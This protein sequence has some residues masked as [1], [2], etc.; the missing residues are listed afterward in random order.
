MIYVS[1][2]MLYTLHV[3]V[4]YV[5][6]NSIQEKECCRRGRNYKKNIYH[7]CTHKFNKRPECG[8]KQFFKAVAPITLQCAAL[9]PSTIRPGGLCLEKRSTV[10]G[11]TSDTMF[12]PS[13]PAFQS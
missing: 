12:E 3:S 7:E 2:S 9:Q 10:T 4:L 8:I 5:N 1:Q 13:S 11:H 6:G